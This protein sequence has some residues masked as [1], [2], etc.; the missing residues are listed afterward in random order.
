MTQPSKTS[1]K[2]HRVGNGLGTWFKFAKFASA[3]EILRVDTIQRN[4]LS[5]SQVF[6]HLQIN[7]Y[8]LILEVVFH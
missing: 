7:T 1:D 3:F 5:R 4:I 2:N 8:S 6:G